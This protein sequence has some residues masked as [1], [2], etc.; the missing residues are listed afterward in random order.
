MFPAAPDSKFC[1]LN[2]KLAFIAASLFFAYTPPISAHGFVQ[3]VIVADAAYP[4][5]NPF[6]DPYVDPLPERVIR[7]I[8]SDGPIT[9][10]QDQNLA[11]NT[12]GESGAALVASGKAG[13]VVKFEW[14]NWPA[15]HLGPVSTYMTSC[16]G[17]CTKFDVNGA[18]WFKIDA[19]GYDDGSWASAKLIS[20]NNTWTSTIPQALAPGQYVMRNEI[21]ALHSSP[22]QYYPSC[23]QVNV[24]GD[25]NAQPSSS[26]IVAIPGLYNGVQFPDIWTQTFDTWDAPGPPV[27]S[28][29][30]N[31]GN[32][33]N[34]AASNDPSLLSAGQ[35]RLVSPASAGGFH[36]RSLIRWRRSR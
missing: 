34:S 6:S 5:W 21:V 26:E 7:K 1:P 4:G 25:G 16:G 31:S 23:T 11:C 12:G 30:D 2:L 18:S 3:T 24:S 32:G 17:D 20:N 22:P 13:S 28:F 33:E 27:V 14:T 9:N 15:D 8:P 10:D 35:C 29:A 19:E 36:R